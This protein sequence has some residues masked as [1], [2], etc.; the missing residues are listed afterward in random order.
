MCCPLPQID[1]HP[2]GVESLLPPTTTVTS[3]Q[4]TE[5][6]G[7]ACDHIRNFLFLVYAVDPHHD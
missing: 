7:T 6:L 2:L 3:K 4:G 1:V 5:K